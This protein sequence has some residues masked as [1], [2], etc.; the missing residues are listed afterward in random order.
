MPGKV[1]LMHKKN[2]IILRRLFLSVP[3]MRRVKGKPFTV[4]RVKNQ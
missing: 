4:T 3:G 2:G 1:F